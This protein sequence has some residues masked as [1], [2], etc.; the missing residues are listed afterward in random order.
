MVAVGGGVILGEGVRLGVSVGPKMVF[1]GRVQ[2]LKMEI[3]Q[4]PSRV[5]LTVMPFLIMVN[6]G[7]VNLIAI[8]FC[9]EEKGCPMI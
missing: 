5:F 3:S 8:S 1:W 2:A 6:D 7:A 4:T 9:K